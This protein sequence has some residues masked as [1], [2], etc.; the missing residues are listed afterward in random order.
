MICLE[1]HGSGMVIVDT[2]GR[3]YARP[4]LVCNQAGFELWKGGHLDSGHD[5]D[6]CRARR[7]GKAPK[8]ETE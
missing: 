2:A 1:C 3:G 5:C 6:D 4:C 8:K 7:K